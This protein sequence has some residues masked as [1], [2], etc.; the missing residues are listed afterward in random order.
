MLAVLENKGCEVRKAGNGYK[1]LSPLTNEKTP[2]FH[3]FEK[4]GKWLFKCFS[5]GEGGDAIDMLCKVGGRSFVEACTETGADHKVTRTST[6]P[7]R[8]RAT[9]TRAPK[10][11]VRSQ[12]RPLPYSNQLTALTQSTFVNAD[13]FEQLRDAPNIMLDYF[14]QHCSPRLAAIASEQAICL[15]GD[16]Y[17]AR[18]STTG[19]VHFTYIDTLGRVVRI[20]AV[21]YNIVADQRML[22][23]LTIKRDKQRKPYHIQQQHGATQSVAHL[24][25]L[26]Y[27]RK[28]ESTVFVVESEKTA[29]LLRIK[30]DHSSCL[31]TGGGSTNI[32]VF[33][34]VRSMRVVLLPDMDKRDGWREVASKL[35]AL[36]VDAVVRNWWSDHESKLQ[37][38]DD[39]GDLVQM[40]TRPQCFDM[41]KAWESQNTSV[42]PS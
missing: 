18:Q 31:A 28:D 7:T 11:F 27:L 35:R 30:F 1:C 39:I 16:P 8:W 13:I 20:K 23:G 22:N 26:P 29:E 9:Q 37:D 19:I 32:N 17:N 25:G 38:T 41:L 10:T 15:N 4:D 5:S 33:H 40:L 2:S 14:A 6:R 3:L 21:R 36:G 34:P 12:T 42:C 24:Y